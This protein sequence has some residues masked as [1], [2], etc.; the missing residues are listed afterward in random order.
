MLDSVGNDALAIW[1]IVNDNAPSTV[2]QVPALRR[3]TLAVHNEFAKVGL[4]LPFVYFR[5]RR[6]QAQLDQETRG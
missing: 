6:E 4:E 1:V 5:T 3:L 2:W